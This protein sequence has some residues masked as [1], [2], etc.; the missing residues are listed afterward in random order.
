MLVSAPSQELP[1]EIG[2]TTI[3]AYSV[4]HSNSICLV[5]PENSY[6]EEI[7]ISRRIYSSRS[8]EWQNWTEIHSVT[9]PDDAKRASEYCDTT[10]SSGIHYEYAIAAR[11]TNWVCG[12]TTNPPAWYYQYVN[13]GREVP[14]KDIRGN[15]ILLVESNL[16][17]SISDELATLTEDLIGDGYKV[18]RHD[19]SANEVTDATWASSVAAAKALIVADYNTNPAADWTLFIVGHVP[20][21]Y[22]G[23]SSPG[24]HSEN[25]GAHAA[26][27]YYAD[28]NSTLW[29]DSTVNN[30]SSIYPHTWNV[31]GDGKFDQSWTP[32]APEMRIGRLDLTNLPAFGKSETELMKQYLKRNHAWRY[33]QYTA[34]DRAMVNAFSRPPESFNSS[35]SF[36]GSLTNCDSVW[37]LSAATSPSNSY[38]LAASY[39]A[40]RYTSAHQVGTTADFA[41]HPLYA[42]FT[43]MYG[44]YFGDWDSAMHPDQVLHAPIAAEGY[45]LSCYYNEN[46]V[47]VDSFAMNEPIGQVLYELAIGRSAGVNA[48]YR[49]GA[50]IVGTNTFTI[51][52][53]MRVFTALMGDPTL[54]ARM[55]APPSNVTVRSEGVDNVLRWALATDSDIQGYHVYRAPVKNLNGFTR[56]TSTPLLTGS[57]I[58]VNGASGEYCYM[59]RTVKLE[60]SENRSFYNASQGVFATL[61]GGISA[62]F[63]PGNGRNLQITG[64]PGRRYTIENTTNLSDMNAWFPLTNVTLTAPTASLGLSESNS[65]IFYRLK[66]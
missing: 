26:D 40:G 61:P 31:P 4:I 13:C 55:V 10:A 63:S 19:V 32:S 3:R 38:L 50:T 33:K 49:Q 6:R 18:F 21:P 30:K 65:V 44:S 53:S 66:E 29:T 52:E 54:R 20:V 51:V 5:W 37:W 11:I 7:R 15:L 27:W 24:S 60:Q 9:N 47:V 42:V 2:A 1:C 16:A 58:D 34:R 59:V 35:A 43:S 39:G 36:F 22:S 57:F 17:G 14:L 41:T 28:V 46:R 45:A 23:D 56:L 62:F 25:V 8:R 48:R 64:Q 12:V